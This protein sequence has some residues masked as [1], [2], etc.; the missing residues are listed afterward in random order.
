M[1]GSKTTGT[2]VVLI[3]RAPSR[4]IARLA[5]VM[6]TDSASSSFPN[7]RFE[8]YQYPCCI[9]S[10]SCAIG[11]TTRLYEVP[12]YSPEKPWLLANSTR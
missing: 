2:C 5:E 11:A 8:V 7:R 9:A 4:R 1:S 12:A 6:P 3:L 10:P